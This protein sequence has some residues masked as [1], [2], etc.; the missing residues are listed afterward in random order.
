[1]RELY[2]NIYFCKIFCIFLFSYTISDNCLLNAFENKFTLSSLESI[3]TQLNVFLNLAFFKKVVV[4]FVH[5]FFAS[6]M[7][8]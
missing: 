6:S 1:M 2:V 3:L 5:H 7:A 8:F 4:N